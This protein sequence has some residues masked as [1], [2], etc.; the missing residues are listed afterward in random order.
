[1]LD[2]AVPII[3]SLGIPIIT[4]ISDAHLDNKEWLW[5]SRWFAY[6]ISQLKHKDELKREF[7][8]EN[9]Q[10]ILEILEELAAPDV[11]LMDKT[12]HILFDGMDSEQL[13]DAVKRG[14]VTVGGHTVRH[15]N[16]INESRDRA[17]ERLSRIKRISRGS[18]GS[19][20]DFL[21]ILKVFGISE[22]AEEVRRAGYIAAF[23]TAIPRPEIPDELLQYSLPRTGIH[24][25]GRLYLRWR[26]TNIGPYFET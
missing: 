16:L 10:R 21:P 25:P 5:F 20:Y 2:Y 13:C 18:S 19:Q 17:G 3:E 14:F 22:I 4:F 15:V 6:E 23:T 26:L 7:S 1:M 11:R 8:N 12:Y 9:I 24:L